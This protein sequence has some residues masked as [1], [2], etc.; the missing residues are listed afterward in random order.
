MKK[1][2]TLAEIII[3]L[4]AIGIL[5]AITLPTLI[6]NYQKKS[7]AIRVKKAYTE[8][9]QAIKLSE[10]DNDSIESWEY[11]NSMSTENT[12]T[13]IEK[14]IAPY[15]KGLTLCSE[16]LERKCGY[17]ISI[18]GANY[19]SMNGTLLSFRADSNSLWL[20]IDVNN[21]SKPNK[22]GYDVFYFA[23]NKKYE[24]RPYGFINGLTRETIK[25]GYNYGGSSLSCKKDNKNN[26]VDDYRH[27]CTALLYLDN[28]EFRKDYPW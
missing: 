5:A 10:V 21:A 7:T 3:T 12:K 23:T 18:A 17:P 2:F 20:I 13:F 1:G 16:G 4:G 28:W 27:G 24:L 19:L 22:M 11:A 15:Y 25:N 9:L 14:Y 6:T 26:P 8:V